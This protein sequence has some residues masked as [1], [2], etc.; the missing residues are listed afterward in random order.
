MTKTKRAS[1]LVVEDEWLVSDLISSVLAHE[2]YEVQ[3]ASNAAEALEYLKSG[4]PPDLLFTD[5]N[6]DGKMNGS[7]LARCARKIHPEIPVVYTSG[8]PSKFD[9]ETQVAGSAFFPK[10]YNPYEVARLVAKAVGKA[11]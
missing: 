5:I 2:G 6:L 3:V 8:R 10:P 9:R 11:A 7:E 4:N 1:V